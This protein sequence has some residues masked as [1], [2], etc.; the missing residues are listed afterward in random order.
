M[1]AVPNVP[2][3]ERAH[4]ARKSARAAKASAQDARAPRGGIG[5]P[6]AREIKAS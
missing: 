3:W 1:R 5:F 6:P 4:P 2:P